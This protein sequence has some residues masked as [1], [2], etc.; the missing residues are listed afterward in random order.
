MLDVIDD[1][2]LDARVADQARVLRDVPQ[3]VL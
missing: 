1:D 2:G 3:A